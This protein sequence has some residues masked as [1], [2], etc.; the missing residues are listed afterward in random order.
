MFKC[1]YGLLWFNLFFEIL[2]YIIY[3]MLW[4]FRVLVG[5]PS[6]L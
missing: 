5:T 4:I 2:F 6:A 1:K 3:Y